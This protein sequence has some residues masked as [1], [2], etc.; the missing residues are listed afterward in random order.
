LRTVSL[1]FLT[2]IN[3]VRFP[4]AMHAKPPTL[5]FPDLK[6]GFKFFSHNSSVGR[7]LTFFPVGQGSYSIA[8][9]SMNTTRPRCCESH[10]CHLC[11]N[12]LCFCFCPGLQNGFSLGIFRRK[13]DSQRILFTLER[14]SPTSAMFVIS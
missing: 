13:P 1:F 2:S 6:L 11:A 14:P 8:A 7:T 3:P 9:S 12:S 4:L 10:W 5:V